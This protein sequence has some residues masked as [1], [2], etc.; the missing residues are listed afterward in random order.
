MSSDYVVAGIDVHK[1]MVAVAVHDLGREEEEFQTGKFCTTASGLRELCEWLKQRNVKEAVMESTAQYWFPVWLALEA[2]FRLHLA[3]AQSNTGPLGRKTD[4]ADAKR[5]V[6]RF[7]AQELRLSFVPEAEQRDWRSLSRARYQLSRERV[8]LQ[9]QI[10]CLLE[11][12]QIKLSSFLTDLLGTGGRKI[13]GAIA[14]GETDPQALAELASSRVRTN[15]AVLQDALCGQVREIHRQLLRLD[16][17]RLAVIEQQV[18]E[19]DQSLEHSLQAHREAIQRLL[20]VPGMGLQAAHQIIAQVGPDAKA[21]ESSR[22]L[23]SWVGVCPGRKESAGVSRSDRSPKG[24][25]AMRRILTQV[26]H[27]AVRT[28]DSYFQTLFRRLITRLGFKKAL[29]AIAHRLCKI[30]WKILH[31]GVHYNHPSNKSPQK[32]QLRAKRLLQQLR[33]LGFDVHIAPAAN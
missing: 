33:S 15:R 29:W 31:D 28:K 21:F 23:S 20:E 12:T 14:N 11:E 30:I 16:L 18:L 32:A 6:R 3:Q 10:E 2:S 1:K 25:R 5:L 19:L 7:A 22:Q 4:Y 8:R 26:A 17:E 13:L 27:G 24:N 9:N